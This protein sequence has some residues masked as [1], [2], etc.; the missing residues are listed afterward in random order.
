M[1]HQVPSQSQVSCQNQQDTSPPPLHKS[2]DPYSEHEH[3]PTPSGY[4]DIIDLGHEY[5]PTPSGYQD[6]DLGHEYHPTPSE[7]QDIDL[8]YEE[9]ATSAHQDTPLIP[10]YQALTSLPGHQNSSIHQGPTSLWQPNPSLQDCRV[11]SISEY[12]G[13]SPLKEQDPKPAGH[14]RCTVTVPAVLMDN[15]PTQ[16]TTG[17]K[18]PACRVGVL[19]KEFTP[20]GLCLAVLCFPCGLFYCFDSKRERCSRCGAN[21]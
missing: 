1:E 9:P 21:F 8:E 14:K 18:C 5:H 15:N 10:W 2:Q 17:K 20:K 16:V 11:M 19:R 13:V 12:P 6:V 3:H 7:Y 4:Q